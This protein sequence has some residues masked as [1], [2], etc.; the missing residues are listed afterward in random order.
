MQDFLEFPEQFKVLKHFDK[1]VFL[2]HANL[3]DAEKQI[4]DKYLGS[5]D[6]IYDIQCPDKSE[7]MVL[8]V[9][10]NLPDNFNAFFLTNFITA[11]AQSFPYH[12]LIVLQYMVKSKLILPVTRPNCTDSRR[13]RV[14]Q[15]FS[16][17]PFSVNLTSYEAGFIQSLNSNI[18]DATSSDE[19]QSLWRRNIIR[20]FCDSAGI[21]NIDDDFRYEC[22]EVNEEIQNM[23]AFENAISVDEPLMDVG[24]PLGEAL[25]DH[26]GY[27][28]NEQN[29]YVDDHYDGD[30][31]PDFFEN[32]CWMLFEQAREAEK[33][34]GIELDPHKWIQ[35]YCIACANMMKEQYGR[36][37]SRVEIRNIAIAFSEQRFCNFETMQYELLTLKE[38]LEQ[39]SFGDEE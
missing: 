38:Y 17:P 36:Y 3:T 33:G 10:I 14:E 26:E 23:Q 18:N 21:R 7:M 8:F 15:I 1:E 9:T 37:L 19:Q 11:V 34:L 5:I 12:C 20:T 25:F 29:N 24:V 4:L 30:D 39:Y 35:D 6:I 16:T 31:Y 13:M 27:D 22:T 32:H 28:I 2:K